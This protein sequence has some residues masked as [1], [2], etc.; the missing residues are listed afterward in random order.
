MYTYNFYIG[1]IKKQA[2]KCLFVDRQQ[3]IIDN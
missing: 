1:F 3:V 2:S